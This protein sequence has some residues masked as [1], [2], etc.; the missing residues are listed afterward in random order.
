MRNHDEEPRETESSA[1]MLEAVVRGV[2][3]WREAH[4]TAT[5]AAIERA[6]D[7]HLAAVRAQLIAETALASAAADLSGRPERE[8]P[9]CRACG[10]ALQAHGQDTRQLATHHGQTL[11]LRR[12]YAVC[13]ACGRGVFPPG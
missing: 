13:P 11:H 10:A 6:V 3:G 2:H 9:R 5:L 8:R 4:P 12:S 1:R 7:E